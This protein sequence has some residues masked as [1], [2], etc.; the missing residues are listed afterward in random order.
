MSTEGRVSTGGGWFGRGVS[1]Q[2]RVRRVRVEGRES[3]EGR[4]GAEERVSTEERVSAELEEF[5]LEGRE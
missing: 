1:E 2:R 3:V 5:T 4:V